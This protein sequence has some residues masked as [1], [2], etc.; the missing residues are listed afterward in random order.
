MRCRKVSRWLLV[1]TMG[2]CGAAAATQPT[3]S[4]TTVTATYIVEAHNTEQAQHIV[5]R[6]GGKVT[7][8][9]P[10][11]QGVSAVLTPA[12]VASLR[13]QGVSVF[14]NA[15]VTTQPS[16]STQP[17]SAVTTTQ[18]S[19][20]VPTT[21]T[22]TQPSTS[23]STQTPTSTSTQP[24]TSTSTQ[25]STSTSTQPSTS[26]ST[27]PS[28]STSTQ[29]ST[30]TS[31]QPSTSYGGDSSQVP[32]QYARGEIGADLLAAQG[33]DGTG[34]TVAILDSGVASSWVQIV[35]RTTG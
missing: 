27:Q 1:A 12:Q 23:T 5:S 13:A 32:N 20:S 9:L 28:T 29:P 15:P 22:S 10:I 16:T 31:T 19:T 35:Q 2:C 21:Q 4:S 34:V 7:G 6:V 3:T 18:P 25:P 30:S 11:V 14:V 17:S 26:T 24:S 33:I 8:N